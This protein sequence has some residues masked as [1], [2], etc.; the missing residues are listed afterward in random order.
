MKSTYSLQRE[1]PE[2]V[3]S[4]LFA[5]SASWIAGV[6]D[7]EEQGNTPKTR[8]F[9]HTLHLRKAFGVPLGALLGFKPNWLQSILVPTQYSVATSGVK[10]PEP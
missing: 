5:A 2:E 10:L 8:G 4:D 9:A 7:I 6:K 1:D 3:A